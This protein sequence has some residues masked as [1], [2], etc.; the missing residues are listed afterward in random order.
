MSQRKRPRSCGACGGETTAPDPEWWRTPEGHA[1]C[2][3]CRRLP[4]YQALAEQHAREAG[5]VVADEGPPEPRPEPLH[6]PP[7]RR[8]T[9]SRSS[10]PRARREASQPEQDAATEERPKVP[11]LIT[12]DAVERRRIAWL[13][14]GWIPAGMLTICDGLPGE[15]K[16]TM[17]VDLASRVTTGRDMPDGSPGVEPGVVLFLS[18]EDAASEILRPRFEAAGADLA[19]VV[20]HHPESDDL[21]QLGKGSPLETW[22]LEHGAKLVIIDPLLTAVPGG[23]DM[24]KGQHARRVL[25]PVGRIADRTGAAIVGVRHFNKGESRSALMRGE[26]SIGIGGTARNVILVG[27]YPSDPDSRVL[28][29]VKSNLPPPGSSRRFAVVSHP[30]IP[31]APYIDWR[32]ES[33]LSADD[34]TGPGDEQP[35]GREQEAI[36]FLRDALGSGEGRPATEITAAAKVA[37]IAPRTLERARAKLGVLHRREEGRSVLYLPDAAHDQCMEGDGEQHATKQ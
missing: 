37:G 30:E 17:L 31:D 33:S 29:R 21:L 25:S 10:G 1:L 19:R 8:V 7:L 3:S 22:I 12:L 16:T 35:Q 36:A 11:A 6:A 13:W 24:H 4:H 32:G 2:L 9:R 15:G 34:L 5:L 26:G 23:V 28:A 18:Y 20:V 14:R 27:K